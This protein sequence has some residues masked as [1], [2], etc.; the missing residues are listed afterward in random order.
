[1]PLVHMHRLGQDEMRL[2]DLVIYVTRGQL[3]SLRLLVSPRL[4]MKFNGIK[5]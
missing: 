4:T 3:M 2:L 1:M 5:T